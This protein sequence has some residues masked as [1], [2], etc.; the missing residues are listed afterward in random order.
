VEKR[1]EKE[2]SMEVLPMLKGKKNKKNN[3]SLLRQ[4]PRQKVE[5]GGGEKAWCGSEERNGL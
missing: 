1:T 4:E 2:E 5:D 3:A